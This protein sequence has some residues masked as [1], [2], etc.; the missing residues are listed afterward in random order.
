MKYKTLIDSGFDKKGQ[1]VD[2]EILEET[3]TEVKFKRAN[4]ETAIYNP[5]NFYSKEMFYKKFSRI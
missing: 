4:E 2:L 1:I 3:D 5:T